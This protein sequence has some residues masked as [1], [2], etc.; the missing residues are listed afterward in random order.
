MRNK[1]QQFKANC[2][3]DAPPSCQ[4]FGL[5]PVCHAPFTPLPRNVGWAK[6]SRA[7]QSKARRVSRTVWH[8]TLHL[9]HN[10]GRKG[11]GVEGKG[12]WS[13]N[14]GLWHAQNIRVRY[15]TLLANTGNT[16]LKCSMTFDWCA[17]WTAAQKCKNT[18]THVCEYVCVWGI[19]YIVMAAGR[20]QLL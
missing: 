2:Q 1:W 10:Q 8:A 6:P 17:L 16:C 9:L 5:V 11:S 4:R 3:L 13:C 19:R 12:G 14:W 7:R 18:N 15:L 20:Y